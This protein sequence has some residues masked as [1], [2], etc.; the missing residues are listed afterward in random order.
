M[1]HL[2]I[3]Y[4]SQSLILTTSHLTRQRDYLFVPD[5]VVLMRL[6]NYAYYG[7]H[8]LA[9]LAY[10][11]FSKNDIQ[12]YVDITPQVRSWIRRELKYRKTQAYGTH[13]GSD[14]D[15]PLVDPDTKDPFP[16]PDK[17][18]VTVADTIRASSTLNFNESISHN[19]V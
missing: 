11:I 14:S 18:L 6:A 4:S 2:I 1:D 15:N 3:H 12:Q 7:W 8:R 13:Y 16:R 5:D 19:P 17:R 10:T 9:N